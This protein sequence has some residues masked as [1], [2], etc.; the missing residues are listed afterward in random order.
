MPTPQL[1]AIAI[2]A[3]MAQIEVPAASKKLMSAAKLAA[4]AN[5]TMMSAIADRI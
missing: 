2:T 3:R 5:S 4:P 1:R